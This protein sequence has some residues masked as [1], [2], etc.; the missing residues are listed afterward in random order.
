MW[1]DPAQKD[2]AAAALR[3]TA[4]DNLEMGFC[5]E[6]IAEPPGGAQHDYDAA[7]A[8]LAAALDKHLSE[9]EKLP[10][11]KLLDSRYQKFRNMAQYFQIV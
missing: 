6:V 3:I 4:R 7:A 9:L 8:A 5:D 2:A 11:E 10:L 1:R